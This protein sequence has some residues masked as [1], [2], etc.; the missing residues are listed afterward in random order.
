MRWI[1]TA[2]ATP[3][4]TSVS[5][6]LSLMIG[7][8]LDT[9][10]VA[11]LANPEGEARVHA[12]VASENERRFYISVLVLGEYQEGLHNLPLAS[13]VRPRIEAALA[14]LERRFAGRL[15]PVS[16]LVVRRWGAISGTVRRETGHSPLVI[17]ML[18]A[19]TAIE[20]D[21]YLTTRN[22]RDVKHSG[23]AVFNPWTDDPAVCQLRA[24]SGVAGKQRR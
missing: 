8:L 14:A 20:D 19:A 7:R 15:L 24:R 18:L 11:E 12:W 5:D 23:A 6:R 21:L 9:N 17:D 1:S 10:V 22:V 16:D 2:S 4:A 3:V 13:G